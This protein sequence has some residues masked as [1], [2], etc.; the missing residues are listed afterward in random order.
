MCL[1]VMII[2]ITM[3]IIIM[4]IIAN[5]Q[6]CKDAS[7]CEAAGQPNKAVRESSNWQPNESKSDVT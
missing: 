7:G 4:I 1:T 3:I 6:L 5:E 2:I